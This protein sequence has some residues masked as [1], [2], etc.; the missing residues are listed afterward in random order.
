MLNFINELKLE[1]RVLSIILTNDYT[2]NDGDIRRGCTLKLL[3]RAFNGET[4]IFENSKETCFGACGGFGFSDGLPD[5]PG[6]VGNFLSYGAGKDFPSGERVKKNPQLGEELILKQPAD[7]LQGKRAI[8]VKPYE[9]GDDA[10]LVT[11]LANPDQLSALVQLFTF[12][13]SDYD[14]VIAPSSSGCS[15]IFRIPLSELKR[16]NPRGVIGNIDIFSRPHFDA[17]TFFFTVPYKSFRQMLANSDSCF[18]ISH[19]WNGVKK[20]L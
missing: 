5:V 19:I 16:E 2:K 11:F 17:D 18:F 20:R 9:E 7:V 8:M 13:S 1:K 12:E 14:N 4:I 3:N 10:A 6:G 15:S